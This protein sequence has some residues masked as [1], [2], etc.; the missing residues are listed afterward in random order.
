MA[1]H[2]DRLR[3]GWE[4]PGGQVALR[5]GG[6]CYSPLAAVSPCPRGRGRLTAAAPFSGNRPGPS[7]GSPGR[8]RGT[9]PPAPGATVDWGGL[10]SVRPDRVAPPGGEAH[11]GR[12]GSAVM[13]VTHPTRL[14]T[15]TKE[16]NTCASRRAERNPVAQ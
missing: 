1:V 11:E 3:V 8:R 5:S 13:S 16:S 12:Q 9:G 2:R 10:S 7:R 15:R 6:E 4:G 14:E